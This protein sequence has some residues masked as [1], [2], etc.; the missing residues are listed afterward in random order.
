[1]NNL[2]DH[3]LIR[4]L[5]YNQIQSIFYS[6]QK[7]YNSIT[8]VGE[9]ILKLLA[10]IIEMDNYFQTFSYFLNLLHLN[11]DFLYFILRI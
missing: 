1:M 10:L 4:A 5:S 3:S 9:P 11:Y 8:A 6:Q 7:Q 2:S